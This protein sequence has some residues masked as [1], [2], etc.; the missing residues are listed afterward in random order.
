MTKSCHATAC[1]PKIGPLDHL[2]QLQLVPWTICGTADGFPRPTMA[3]WLVPR[4]IQRLS[5]FIEPYSYVKNCVTFLVELKNSSTA[6]M[7]VYISIVLITIYA[8]AC[9]DSITVNREIFVYENIHA[10]NIRVNK[11][12]R[13]PHKN[14]L[15][16]KICQVEITVHVWPIKRLLAM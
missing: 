13:V 12:S 1:P 8:S 3:P 15:T 5:L 7:S 6:C 10:L 2:W 11:F 9:S 14:I 4:I 16:W